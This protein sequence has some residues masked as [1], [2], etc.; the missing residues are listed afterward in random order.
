MFVGISGLWLGS[1]ALVGGSGGFRGG[2]C[3]CCA[4][5]WVVNR[6]AWLF[7]FFFFLACCGMVVVAVVVGV[8][9]VLARGWSIGV[10]GDLVFYF[11]FFFYLLWIGGGC[12]YD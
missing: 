10:L 7:E 2:G 12:G 11:Y 6:S 9:V 3:G 5:S 1:S 4:C 8:G